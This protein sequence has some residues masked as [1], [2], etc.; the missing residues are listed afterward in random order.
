MKAA[1]KSRQPVTMMDIPLSA[2]PHNLPL[3]FGLVFGTIMV[4]AG[5]LLAAVGIAT[6]RNWL[7]SAS[8]PE[9]PARIV[10]SEVREE[11]R[12]EDQL[13]YRPVVTY[14]F[15]AGGGE[16]VGSTLAFADALYPTR[17]R[18]EKALARYPVGMTVMARYN[19]DDPQE[20]VLVRRG[21]VAA[22]CILALGL[23][24]FIVPLAAA[25]RAGLPAGEIGGGLA[26]A[27]A[28]LALS[29]RH[30]AKRR[31]RARLEGIYPPPGRGSD[32][33]V[34][35]LLRQGEKMLA[36]RLYREIHATDL[37]T[38]RLRVEEMA[39]RIRGDAR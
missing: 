23:A 12:F 5:L 2:F 24:M 6:L 22:L 16:M 13:M 31:A 30:V 15:A 17:A 25:W 20:A 14:T 7:A 36:I 28:V 33:D 4:L 35:R 34:E 10:T 26:L 32:A 29:G 18:A 37:M 38:S 27:T 19:P 21:A 3:A 39:A 11:L 8:W 1:A 9:V